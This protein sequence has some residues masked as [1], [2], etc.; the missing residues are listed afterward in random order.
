MQDNIMHEI[1]FDGKCMLLN[2]IE[3]SDMLKSAFQFE[4]YAGKI[5]TSA[6]Q[7][8]CCWCRE[9]KNRIQTFR[10]LN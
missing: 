2:G 5:Y 7:C 3:K 4:S 1:F 6:E 9:K 10:I 8:S